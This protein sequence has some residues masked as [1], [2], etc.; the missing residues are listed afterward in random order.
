MTRHGFPAAN[1]PAGNDFVT[2]LLAPT[3]VSSPISTPGRTIAPPPIPRRGELRIRGDV[4]FA[5]QHLV[6]LSD[7]AVA[8]AFSWSPR[9]ARTERHRLPSPDALWQRAVGSP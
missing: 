2:T 8:R 6:A 9:A 3:T 1:T 7:H 5:P 4:Q